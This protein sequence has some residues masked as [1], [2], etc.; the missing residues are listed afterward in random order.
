MKNWTDGEPL[1]TP[2]GA[3]HALGVMFMWGNHNANEY[4]AEF[5]GDDAAADGLTELMI[6]ATGCPETDGTGVSRPI[7]PLNL[8]QQMTFLRDCSLLLHYVLCIV[9]CV[10]CIVYCVLCIVY[11]VLCIVY[12]V[13][14]IVYYVLCVVDCGLWIVDCVLWE[15]RSLIWEYRSLIWEETYRWGLA[16]SQ[17][18]RGVSSAACCTSRLVYSIPRCVFT[19]SAAQ[20]TTRSTPGLD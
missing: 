13:L 8:Q 10:L 9:Y 2:L 17:C 6:A 1:P 11:C 3:C 15:Y 5:C 20:C 14:C 12:Y 16:R 7:C 19:A 18:N 4:L